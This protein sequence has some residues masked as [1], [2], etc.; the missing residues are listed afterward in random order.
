MFI[1]KIINVLFNVTSFRQAVRA[2]AGRQAHKVASKLHKFHETSIT[3]PTFLP[4]EYCRL[5]A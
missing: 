2:I 3:S 4:H 5:F 1:K